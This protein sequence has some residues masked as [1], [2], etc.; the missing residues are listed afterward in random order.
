[1][2]KIQYMDAGVTLQLS[3]AILVAVLSA[4]LGGN[5]L[6]RQHNNLSLIKCSS[7]ALVSDSIITKV[8]QG[9]SYWSGKNDSTGFG[10]VSCAQSMLGKIDCAQGARRYNNTFSSL[11]AGIWHSPC[12]RPWGLCWDVWTITEY[13]SCLHQNIHIS[14]WRHIVIFTTH[15][16]RNNVNPFS[17]LYLSSVL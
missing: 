5:S 12:Y 1:M 16:P 8:P 10:M 11:T 13:L 9:C 2:P 17:L 4:D 6:V 15:F 14:S 3:R 7:W